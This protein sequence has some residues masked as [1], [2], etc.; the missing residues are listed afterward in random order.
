MGSAHE[1][2]SKNRTWSALN[3]LEPETLRDIW[4]N[5]KP[6]QIHFSKI[7]DR[8][9]PGPVKN[10]AP[11]RIK[12]GEILRFQAG[13]VPVQN[14]KCWSRSR[15]FSNRGLDRAR[16]REKENDSQQTPADEYN[17]VGDRLWRQYWW[18]TRRSG[19][20]LIWNNLS[21]IRFLWI[22]RIQLDDLFMKVCLWPLICLFI[23]IREFHIWDLF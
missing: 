17:D 22:R 23:L 19:Q 18:Q 7:T 5:V 4:K 12:T 8:S 13:P 15:K 6:D 3:W 9:W 14:L 20:L 1:Q 16:T 11:D 2:G 10:E 21:Q